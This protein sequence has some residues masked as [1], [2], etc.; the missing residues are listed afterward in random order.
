VY[1][2]YDL[3]I[4]ERLKLIREE[5]KRIEKKYFKLSAI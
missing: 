1:L 4:L 5:E 2:I 3:L